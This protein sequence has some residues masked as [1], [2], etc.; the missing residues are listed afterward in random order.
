MKKKASGSVPACSS[1]DPLST[2][3]AEAELWPLTDE[4]RADLEEALREMERGE[5][6]SE[7]EMAEIYRLA[8]RWGAV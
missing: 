2:T 1:P 4:E 6:A 5:V 8:G 7:A 3:D